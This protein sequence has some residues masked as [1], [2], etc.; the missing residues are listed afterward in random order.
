[1]IRLLCI[2]LGGMGRSDWKNADQVRS[3]RL[4]A[5]VDPADEPRAFFAETTGS[6][7]FTNLSEALRSVRAD[8]AL[9]STPDQFHAPYSIEAM[10]AG[11]DVIVEKPM[12][13]N[14]RDA[15]RMHATAE[16]LGRMLMVHNQMRWFPVY[17]KLHQ[18]VEKGKIGDLQS[19]EFDMYVFSD[20]CFRGYRSRVPQLMLQDLGIH[21]LDL[22]RFMTGREF[23]KV[24]AG[25]WPSNEEGASIKATTATYAVLEMTG[26]V[27]VSYRSK[28]RA[29]HDETGYTGRVVLTG[30]RG[31]L[32]YYTEGAGKIVFQSFKGRHAKAKPR[33]IDPGPQ[34]KTAMAAFADAMRKREPAL[35]WSGDNLKSL[36]ATFAA[37]KSVESGRVVRLGA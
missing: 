8:A 30:S 27:K 3:F 13:E 7:T 29:I 28:M 35:T 22:C 26:S 2:G 37:I 11:L 1:M 25:S 18:L 4:V 33:E 20:A 24:Y 15:K 23:T 14:M 19:V 9:I 12:A 32:G 10:K 36:E 31:M 17:R 16:R 5:G 6:P 21:H 34:K